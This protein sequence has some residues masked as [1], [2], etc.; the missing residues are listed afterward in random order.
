MASS[1]RV[2]ASPSN[3]LATSQLPPPYRACVRP[4]E[5]LKPLAISKMR[6][7]TH[8]RGFRTLLRVCTPPDRMTAVMAIVEDEDGTA[9]LLQL[10]HQPAESLGSASHILKPGDILLLKEPYFKRALDGSYGVRVDHPCDI[11]TLSATDELVPQKWRDTL[12]RPPK[13]SSH[14]LR[15]EGNEAVQREKWSE[16]NLLYS[17]A[18]EA[19]DTDED[20]RLAYLNRA[21]TNLR[22][23][24]AEKALDDTRLGRDESSP[25]EK[26][27]YREVRALYQLGRYADCLETLQVLL[28]RYPDSTIGKTE[29]ARVEARLG[30]QRRGEYSFGAMYQ[31]ARSTPPLIDAAT[32]SA[33]AEIRESPGR[34]RGLFTTGPVKA[35]QLLLCEKA[36]AYV[37]AEEEQGEPLTILMNMHTKRAFMGGQARLL[38]QLVQKLLHDPEALRLYSDLY[39]GGGANR[40]IVEVDGCHVVDSFLV[41]DIMAL[42]CFGAPRISRGLLARQGR[43]IESDVKESGHSTTGIWLLASRINHSCTGNCRRSF[44][45]DM[46]IVRATRDLEAGTELHFGY[47]PFDPMESYQDVQK[48]LSN[49][50]FVCD[51][52]ICAVRKITP[53]ETVETRKRLMGTLKTIL[54]NRSRSGL[55]KADDLLAKIEKSYTAID[56]SSPKLCLWDPYFVLGFDLI[57]DAKPKQGIRMIAKGFEALGFKMTATAPDSGTEPP[58]LEVEEWGINIEYCS[59]AFMNLFMAYKAVYPPMSDVARSYAKVAYCIE[60]GEGETFDAEYRGFLGAEV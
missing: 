50:R 41:N 52:Q 21:L 28:A 32:Y 56:P 13:R 60:V 55:R 48:G 10:Y 38:P 53:R 58:K 6:L 39:S 9:V 5:H 36:F 40:P 59:L 23:G 45:G 16:A 12:P 20:R 18:I 27:L 24:R 54:R 22:L 29:Q 15:M 51:C 8:H 30:E 1:L 33:P 44:I 17:T 11:V 57:R 31:Q 46:L 47:R 42:N 34:G 2:S 14:A 7:E 4:I 3:F 49:R 43:L 35:G 19:A 37:F 26:S 25:S